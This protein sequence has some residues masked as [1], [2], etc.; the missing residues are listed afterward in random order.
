[1]MNAARERVTE[2]RNRPA[3]GGKR[4]Q[5]AK[6]MFGRKEAKELLKIK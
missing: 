4:P 2:L 3:G 6:K 1:M 5:N